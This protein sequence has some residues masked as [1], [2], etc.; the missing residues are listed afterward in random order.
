MRASRCSSQ[1][2][3]R[4]PNQFRKNARHVIILM[5]VLLPEPFGRRFP[6][7][8]RGR[9]VKLALS[10]AADRSRCSRSIRKRFDAF[11]ERL[12]GDQPVTP[13]HKLG[14][15]LPVDLAKVQT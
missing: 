2:Y 6:H 7:T 1:A 8:T 15:F 5:V 14:H 10:T 9:T 11:G 3:G 12:R 13:G 4:A